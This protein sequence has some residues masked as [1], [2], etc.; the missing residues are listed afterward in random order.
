MESDHLYFTSARAVAFLFAHTRPRRNPQN[1][2]N[3]RA[4]IENFARPPPLISAGSI[5]VSPCSANSR[6]CL[7]AVVRSLN[8]VQGNAVCGH[9]TVRPATL[10]D[11][12]SM[13]PTGNGILAACPAAR[14]TDRSHRV[15]VLPPVTR[16]RRRGAGIAERASRAGSEELAGMFRQPPI[17]PGL[18]SRCRSVP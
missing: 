5:E 15:P 16:K 17:S 10:G 6:P 13:D 8:G 9:A 3:N 4:G 7:L 14:H 12:A 2:R 1:C 11:K 18:R